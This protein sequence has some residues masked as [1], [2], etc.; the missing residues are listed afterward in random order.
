[1][2]DSDYDAR[3]L[4]VGDEVSDV[5]DT[6]DDDEEEGGYSEMEENY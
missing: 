3:G 1:V 4:F 2:W 5:Q 6:S